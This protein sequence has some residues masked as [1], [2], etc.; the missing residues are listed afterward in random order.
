VLWL[1][2]AH[3]TINIFSHEFIDATDQ[4]A[5]QCGGIVSRATTNKA[6]NKVIPLAAIAVEALAIEKTLG[7]AVH[8]HSV[9]RDASFLESMRVSSRPNWSVT[10]LESFLF[11]IFFLFLFDHAGTGCN[12]TTPITTCFQIMRRI[13]E[14]QYRLVVTLNCQRL[15]S[16]AKYHLCSLTLMD[17]GDRRSFPQ[18]HMDLLTREAYDSATEYAAAIVSVVVVFLLSSLRFPY[19]SRAHQK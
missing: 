19:V 9:H 16:L 4:L 7:S 15:S 17:M 11:L 3:Y 2:H 18:E 1:S 6:E 10:K 13:S 14:N 8:A 5:S 12:S